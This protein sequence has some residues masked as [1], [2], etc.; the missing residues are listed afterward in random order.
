MVSSFGLYAA[1]VGLACFACASVGGEAAPKRP[2]TD[3]FRDAKYGVFQHFLPDSRNGPALVKQFDVEALADQLKAAGAGYYIFTLGQNS[4]WLN[5]PN[6]AYDR[7]TGYAPGERC[8]TRDLP[9]DLYTA[10]HKRGIRLMLYLPCQPPNGD[11]RAQKA[12]GLPEGPAD[13]PLPPDVAR[14]WA[15]V[16]REWSDRYGDK[17]VGWWF[18]GGY[19]WIGFNEEIAGIYNAAVKHGNPKALATFNPGVKVIRHTQAEDYT[20]GELNEP[21]G[22]IPAARTLDGSQ[23]HALTYL[24][25]GWGQRAPRFSDEQWAQWVAAVTAKGGVAS[26]DTGPNERAEDGPIGAISEAHMATLKA[27]RKAVRPPGKTPKRLRRSE[28][29]VGIHYDFHA[30][31]TDDQIGANTSREMIETIIDQVK[32]DYIQIDCKGHPG[33]SS[34]PTK[35]GYPAAGFV[36]DPLRVWREVTARRGVALYMH[37]SGVWDAEAIRQHPDWAVVNADGKRDE[38]TTSRFSA[39]ADQLMIPQLKELGS[40]YD[41]DGVWV[42]GDCWASKP[43]YSEPALAAFRKATGITDVPRQPGDPHWYEF[44]QFNRE[45]FRDYMRHVIREVKKTAPRLQY[46]SN[47]AFS[48]HMPE[49]VCA[50]V[51]FISGD[52]NPEDSV[53]SA[54][55]S[56]R[57]LAQGG[58]PWDLMAWSFTRVA[59]KNG[60]HQKTAVQ[61]QREAAV[62]LS[63]GGGFQAYFTQRRDG[64]VKLSE[65]PLMAEVARFCRARQALCHGA[66]IVPQVALLFSMVDHYHEA[67]GLFPR[68]LTHVN[69][70]LQALLESQY[71]VELLGEAN[72]HGRMKEYPLIVI[73]EARTLEPAFE[74]ELRAYVKGGGHLLLIGPESAERFSGEIG[75]L[76]KEEIARESRTLR[77]GDNRVPTK[78]FAQAVT[79]EAKARPFGELTAPGAAES[80]PAASFTTVGKGVIAATYTDLSEAYTSERSPAAREFLHTLAQELFPHPLVTVTGSRDV[81]VTVTRQAGRL[82]ISL[83]NTA[84]PHADPHD[85]IIESIPTVGPLE[86]A[87]QTPTA[88]KAIRWEP[89]GTSLPVRYEAG[90]A[91][92]TLPKLEIH[93][94]LVVE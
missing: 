4:G 27:I 52:L 22:E 30:N 92:V 41:V 61:L 93:G 50:P 16:I 75:Y 42:D 11:P 56:A 60:S 63:Q 40:V 9:L 89:D 91:T 76:P 23:W 84:G 18:D 62:A 57:F 72:L 88:P 15:D 44:L 2:S 5:A 87:I 71:S 39:Y 6:A 82:A 55:A 83:M 14:K 53:N 81:D 90:V 80:S 25:A 67:N 31:P 26:L 29:Y 38:M 10:L 47:W 65:V 69:G 59:G 94:V 35:V 86:V 36:G 3:W 79:L 77:H 58:K 7:I 33:I 1:L 37:Y 13:Q 46:C 17:V 32:P 70:P 74:D 28:S 45:A 64:S 43:D 49:P 19:D 73:P 21:L 48:D 85:P 20:A 34:Y 24:G 8:S 51:D 12:F 68:D 78:G 54:R 66:K